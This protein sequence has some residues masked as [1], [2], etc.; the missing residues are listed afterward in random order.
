MAQEREHSTPWTFAESANTREG[1]QQG[2]RSQ[3][4]NQRAEASN[5]V[6]NK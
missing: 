2:T 4:L 6:R 5:E 1:L 3:F